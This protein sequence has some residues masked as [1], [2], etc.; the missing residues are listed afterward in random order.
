M[1]KNLMLSLLA[2][3]SALCTDLAFAG[4]DIGAPS[5]GPF[6]QMGQWF[7]NYIDFMDGPF[8][9][10]AVVVSIILAVLTWN[11]MPKEGIFGSVLRTVISALVVLNVG[12]WVTSFV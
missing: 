10:G 11:F 4:Y 8:A 3:S 2:S 7:Q 12:T 5:S 9:V 6:A 1:K